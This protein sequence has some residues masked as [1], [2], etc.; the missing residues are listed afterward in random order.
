MTSELQ[1]A[2]VFQKVQRAISERLPRNQ[3]I[4]RNLPGHG[5]IRIDRQLPFLCL[6]RQPTDRPDDGTR[7]LVTTEAAYLAISGDSQYLDDVRE[8]VD[9]VSRLMLEHFGIYLV[10]EV[11]SRRQQRSAFPRRPRFRIVAPEAESMMTALEL[12]RSSLESIQVDGQPAEVE[13]DSS[14]LV[15]PPG[16]APL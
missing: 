11:W 10:L 2:T 1:D 3:K 13:V 15:A 14:G 4:R 6:Y 7:E 5:R 9:V 12:F 16:L 8:M